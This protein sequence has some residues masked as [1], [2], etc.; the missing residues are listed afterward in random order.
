MMAAVFGAAQFPKETHLCLPLLPTQ[1]PD[2]EKSAAALIISSFHFAPAPHHALHH[3]A[4]QHLF[5]RKAP[6]FVYR[7]RRVRH[8]FVYRHTKTQANPS[9]ISAWAHRIHDNALLFRG[10][11]PALAAPWHGQVRIELQIIDDQHVFYLFPLSISFAKSRQPTSTPSA[12]GMPRRDYA[13]E[14]RLAIRDLEDDVRHQKVFTDEVRRMDEAKTKW[15]M[16]RFQDIKGK[17]TAI[18]VRGTKR[19]E[20]G[21]EEKRKER[22]SCQDVSHDLFTHLFKFRMSLATLRHC[23]RHSH[24]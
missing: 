6:V 24:R 19:R 8:R 5:L 1:Q 9:P 3:R 12:A 4:S 16:N 18:M 21:R 2:D 22:A 23:P 15:K 17:V 7:Q 11:Q 13:R 10:R 20:G 14:N